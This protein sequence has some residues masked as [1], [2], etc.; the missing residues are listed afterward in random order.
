MQRI[1]AVGF[2][3]TLSILALLLIAGHGPWA[4]ETIWTLDDS[5][6]LNTGDVPVLALWG[7]GMVSCGVL[8]WHG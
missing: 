6:G 8:W 7:F 1:L 3:L 2:F 5:H 4:G